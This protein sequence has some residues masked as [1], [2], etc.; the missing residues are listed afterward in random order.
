LRLGIVV[1][2][3]NAALA[4]SVGLEGVDNG[5]EQRNA[6]AIVAAVNAAGGV[7]GRP[8]QPVYFTVKMSDA[9][10]PSDELYSRVCAYFTQ[11]HDTRIVLA[12]GVIT[13]QLWA[14][15]KGRGGLGIGGNTAYVGDRTTLGYPVLA[16][17]A[18]G[19]ERQLSAQVDA[20]GAGGFFAG[21]QKYALLSYDD[22]KFRGAVTRSLKPALKARGITLTDEYYLPPIN[23]LQDE[24]SHSTA[25][26]SAVLRFRGDGVTRVILAEGSAAGALFF[27]RQA[28]GQGYRPRYGLT[29]AQFLNTLAANV[30]ASQLTGSVAL[31]WWPS[32]DLPSDSVVRTPGRARCVAALARAGIHYA[33]NS[34][35]EQT[36]FNQ[37]D[38]VFAAVDSARAAA[39]TSPA[40]VLRGARVLG[41]RWASAAA[42]QSSFATRDAVSGYR[43][44]LFAQACSCFRYS[45]PN[46]RID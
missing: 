37:C 11:D 14:C 1:T 23:G 41:G 7:G 42:V 16:P 8:V 26:G 31:G 15:L 2:E 10:T 5:D 38:M 19:L 4:S 18:L 30:P 9:N 28:D 35:Q 6:A 22:P 13:D 34:S 45:G 32:G 44:A 21:A 17:N 20:L 3:N 25:A 40:G 43:V 24:G 46:R 12:S 39:D 27:M 33:V 29:S 36:A